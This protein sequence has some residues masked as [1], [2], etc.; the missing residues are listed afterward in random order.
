MGKVSGI[1]WTNATWNPW[2]GCRKLS[3]GCAHCYMFREKRQYGQDPERVVRSKTTFAD[4]LRW[5]DPQVI[6]TCSW[7]DFFIQEADAWR[8]EA[9]DIIRDTP[10]HTYLILTKR[11]RRIAACLPDGWPLANCWLGVSVENSAFYKR[12]RGLQRIA[13]KHFL[14]LEPMLSPM[15]NLPFDQ[16][17]LDGIGW[18]IVGGESGSGCR[19]IK[20][21]WV[22]DVRDQCARAGV[23][24]FF[25]QWSSERP[26]AGGKLLQGQV[27]DA[28]PF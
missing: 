17:G 13:G 22:I 11:Y 3:P 28:R 14:S 15:P 7:G 12:I 2:H 23:P 27:Y 9:W 21:E 1:E 10:Q 26:G 16:A 19:E 6:F 5:K 25:K 18:V 24:F 4:P 8:R 20:E